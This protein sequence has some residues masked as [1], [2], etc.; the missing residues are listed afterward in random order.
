MKKLRGILAVLLSMALF[1]AAACPAGAEDDPLIA[2]VAPDEVIMAEQA[3]PPI[4]DVGIALDDLLQESAFEEEAGAGADLEALL[5]QPTGS[6]LSDFVVK[7]APPMAQSDADG[8]LSVCEGS[9]LHLVEEAAGAASSDGFVVENGVLVE[10]KGGGWDI[11]IPGNVTSIDEKA[12]SRCRSVSAIQAG[13]NATIGLINLTSVTIP[14]SVTYIHPSAFSTC[15]KATFKVEKGSY[16]EQYCIDNGLNYKTVEPV[17]EHTLSGILRK[18]DGWKLLWN[19]DG[20][21]F[22]N[23]IMTGAKLSLSVSGS[24]ADFGTIMTYN[25]MDE[26]N[27]PWLDEDN[28]ISKDSFAHISISGTASNPLYLITNM[29]K[30]YCNV[31]DVSMDCVEQIGSYAFSSCNSLKTVNGFDI[32]L[33]VIESGAFKDCSLLEDITYDR[34]G[35]ITTP[36]NLT[37]IGEEAFKN[38]ALENITLHPSVTSI[39]ADAF[40]G[41]PN[42]RIYCLRNTVAHQYA[43]ANNISYRFMPFFKP[44]DS[45]GFSNSYTFFGSKSENYYMNDRDRAKFEENQDAGGREALAGYINDS[46]GGSC[47]GMTATSIFCKNGLISPSDIQSGAAHLHDI[48]KTNNDDVESFINFYQMTQFCNGHKDAKFA[49]GQLSVQQQV[50]R[51]CTL[52][53]KANDGEGP[54]FME[55]RMKNGGQHAIVGY[56]MESDNFNMNGK[57][58]DTKILIYDCSYPDHDSAMYCNR[59]SSE[60]CFVDWNVIKLVYIGSNVEEISPIFTNNVRRRLA[61]HIKYTSGMEFSLTMQGKGTTAINDDTFDAEKGIFVNGIT[62]GDSD[63]RLLNFMNEKNDFSIQPVGNADFTY[64]SPSGLYDIEAGKA[65]G[66]SF[67]SNGAMSMTD[68][69]GDYKVSLVVDESNSSTPWTKTRISGKNSDISISQTNAGLLVS[70]NDLPNVSIVAVNDSGETPVDL[71]TDQNTVL[72]T[73]SASSEKPAPIAY[74]DKDGDG[75]F[76]TPVSNGKADNVITALSFDR[77]EITLTPG[78]SWTAVVNIEPETAKDTALAWTSSDS[79]TVSVKDGVI[80]AHKAGKATVYVAPASDTSKQ[81]TIEVYVENPTVPVRQVTLPQATVELIAGNNCYMPATVLPEDATDKGLVYSSSN[82]AVAAYNDGMIDAIAPGT[83]VITAASAADYS[84][85]ASCTVTVVEKI[86][87]KD[88]AKKGKN[89]TV[90]WIVGGKL[91][92]LPTFATDE[93]YAVTGYKSSKPRVAT[94]DANGLVTA[95]GEGKAKITITTSSKKRKATITVKITDPNKPTGVTISQGKAI[96]IAMGTPLQLTAA[97]VPFAA[98]SGLTW[99][100]SKTKV[101]T[102]DENGLVTPVR[103]GKTKITVTT[104]NKKKATITVTVV[105]PFKPTS[106]SLNYSG[107]VTLKVGET[108]QLKATMAPAE[109]QS[110][111]GWSSSKKK[112]ASIAVAGDECT[113]TA[114]K[115]GTARITVQTWNKKKAV[116]KVVV[117][118]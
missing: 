117:V 19:I 69:T 88:V 27:S 35:T 114:L 81:A 40:S 5:A 70:S 15:N 43:E 36:N 38:T 102:V 41:C 7:E 33:H 79:S 37:I 20:G 110:G 2:E 11:V 92:L 71:N 62:D 52:A 51:V 18:G 100:S 78:A 32:Y 21:T 29:F 53:E 73:G 118:K 84:K 42:L 93:G 4:E 13:A 28:G 66:I 98:Q 76:E 74:E 44:Y 46:W 30:G 87:Q 6:D 103:E 24:N 1:L 83:A 49:F 3:E 25:E 31:V 115:K 104:R 106:V 12:F 26:D 113:V 60:F 45:W 23:G 96:T 108:L 90:N 82:T 8:A 112:V 14:G 91:Q 107:T 105:D 56:G 68:V 77:K 75:V 80:T 57:R 64:Y 116:I 47:Y 111:L 99:K 59:G 95:V 89:G 55:I 58:Y 17:V 22:L 85:S 39:G 16:A 50:E 10:Y 97:L 63:I 65:K 101:A 109:A 94:V 86:P 54:F 9:D 67:T 61:T 34:D 72:L 48:T